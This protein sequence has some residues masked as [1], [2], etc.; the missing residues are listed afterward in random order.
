MICGL[1]WLLAVVQIGSSYRAVVH[2]DGEVNTASAASN[3]LDALA[4]GLPS[5]RPASFT[6]TRCDLLMPPSLPAF[7]SIDDLRCT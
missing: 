2:T 5:I 6:S 3:V 1:D 4:A 7:T